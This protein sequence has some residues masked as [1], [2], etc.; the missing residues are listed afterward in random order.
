MLE[1]VREMSLELV[2]MPDATHAS[3]GYTRCLRRA[4][5]AAIRRIL[6]LL[7]NRHVHDLLDLFADNGWAQTG[8]VLQAARQAFRDPVRT[9]ATHSLQSVAQSSCNYLRR[10]SMVCQQQVDAL[11]LSFWGA[12]P[13]RIAAPVV[14][15]RRADR[16][17]LDTYHPPKELLFASKRESCV[18][19]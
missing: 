5:Y 7:L 11:Q 4:G 16:N 2:R 13:S 6:R 3:I 14:N 1:R 12:F 9:P 15:I 8:G 10:R 19:D 18:G 17:L